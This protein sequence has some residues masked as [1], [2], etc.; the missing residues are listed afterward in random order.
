[1]WLGHR[2]HPHI[3]QGW[4]PRGPLRLGKD[5]EGCGSWGPGNKG[6]SRKRVNCREKGCGQTMQTEDSVSRLQPEQRCGGG[7]GQPRVSA[8]GEEL[9]WK[10]KRAK[11]QG[12]LYKLE[13]CLSMETPEADQETRL[14]EPTPGQGRTCPPPRSMVAQSCCA[15]WGSQVGPIPASSHLRGQGS[16]STSPPE[17]VVPAPPA[18]VRSKLGKSELHPQDKRWLEHRN[19]THHSQAWA[20]PPSL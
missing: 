6:S 12:R 16:L 8:P 15:S 9:G 10:Q 13:C 4:G 18:E 1:M 3:C 14:Q 17:A 2:W 7:T 19:S 20:L 5:L 11:K